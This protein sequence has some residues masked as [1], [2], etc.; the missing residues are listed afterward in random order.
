MNDVLTGCPHKLAAEDPFVPPDF[1]SGCPLCGQVRTLS[2]PLASAVQWTFRMYQSQL[3]SAEWPAAMDMLET[4]ASA[5]CVRETG[6]VPTSGDL[7]LMSAIALAGAQQ[8]H[9]AGTVGPTL[10]PTARGAHILPSTRPTVQIE[11]LP[12]H[13]GDDRP[14]GAGGGGGGRAGQS[15]L[16]HRRA[17][18][19]GGAIRSS[20]CRI[21]LPRIGPLPG[22][23]RIPVP[24]EVLQ[25]EGGLVDAP[26]G[27]DH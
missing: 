22:G 21:T 13:P 7:G 24:F 3:G 1:E 18:H 19:R 27:V 4:V 15:V 14:L 2:D 8:A 20:C 5:P 17:L 9:L 10:L 23:G 11:Y 6:F 12:V 25:S 16:R 26:D